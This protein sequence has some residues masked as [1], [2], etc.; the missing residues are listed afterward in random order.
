MNTHTQKNDFS[1]TGAVLVVSLIILTVMTLIGITA[2][3]TTI[4]Q[5][6]MAGNSRDLNM[7]FEAAEAANR[8]G[9]N[10]IS[11][12]N[13]IPD[14]NAVCTP[15]DCVW[16]NENGAPALYVATGASFYTDDILWAS[17]RE[18]SHVNPN[19]EPA[20]EGVK[21]LPRFVIEFTEHRRD[22]QNLGQQQ[23]LQNSRSVYRVTSRGTGGTDASRAFVQSNFAK[24]F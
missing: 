18:S 1:Q 20:L 21:T 9:E 2:M 11:G 3:Q 24:R 4:L 8:E 6:R 19:N 14:P 15:P 23:D 10:W 17:A 7:A 12:L 16:N 22:S 5:E 13:T